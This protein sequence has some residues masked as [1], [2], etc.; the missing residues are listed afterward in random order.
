MD[1]PAPIEQHIDSDPPAIPLNEDTEGSS[2]ISETS[3]AS[4]LDKKRRGG[5]EMTSEISMVM[6][7]LTDKE[8]SILK[9]S[10]AA[11]RDDDPDR[12]QV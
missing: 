10:V 11:R 8:Q 1:L 4:G 3:E 9:E 5:I 6:D 2:R 7:T 12:D